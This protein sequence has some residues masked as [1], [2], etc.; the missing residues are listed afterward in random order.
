M[1]WGREGRGGGES[2]GRRRRSDR[3]DWRRNGKYRTGERSSEARDQGR[4]RGKTRGQESREGGT[5]GVGGWRGGGTGEGIVGRRRAIELSGQSANGTVAG[6][7]GAGEH[8][9]AIQGG[10][11]QIEH[12]SHPA[13]QTPNLHSVV[14]E[15]DGA[16]RGR[17]GDD[18][19]GPGLTCGGGATRETGHSPAPGHACHGAPVAGNFQHP[20]GYGM[21]RVGRVLTPLENQASLSNVATQEGVLSSQGFRF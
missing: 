19:V 1:G 18:G 21:G 20:W 9:G 12:G 5:E 14:G 3:R 8:G 2:T 15:G 16:E 6:L 7:A 13:G 4:K 11:G 17:Q 10:N